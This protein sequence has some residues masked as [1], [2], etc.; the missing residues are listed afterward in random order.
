MLPV[1]IHLKFHLEI[2]EFYLGPSLTE[3]FLKGTKSRLYAI[4]GLIA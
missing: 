1:N 2:E 4:N 3:L